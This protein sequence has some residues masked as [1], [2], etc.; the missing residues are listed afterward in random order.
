[1]G[2]IGME[3]AWARLT[4]TLARRPAPPPERLPLAGAAGRVLAADLVARQDVPPFDRATMDGYAVGEGEAGRILEVVGEIHAGDGAVGAVGADAEV[5]PAPAPAAGGAGLRPGTAVRIMTGAPVPPGA[6]RVVMVEATREVDGG[7]RVEILDHGRRRNIAPRGEDLRAGAVAARAG[8]RLTPARLAGL[9]ACGLDEAAVAPRPRVAVLVTGDELVERA[10]DLAPG[11]ILNSNGPLLAGL[12]TGAGYPVRTGPPVPDRPGRT[13]DRIAAALEGADLL[14][15]SGG[16]SAGTRD[17]V[18]GALAALGLEIVFSRVRMKPG[19][20]VTLAVGGRGLA[21]GLPGNPVSVFVTAHLFLLPALAWLEGERA[22]PRWLDLPAAAD[23]AAPASERV[24]LLPARL[25]GRGRWELL[26]YHGS[27]HLLALY[28][29]DGLVRLDPGAERV[30]AGQE[31]P[32][33]PVALP[34]YGTDAAAG[35]DGTGPE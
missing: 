13:R 10:A 22:R 29:A 30:A 14:V 2:M 11:R 16:V 27:G 23:Q 21:L 3:E 33:W 35:A 15:L 9:L 20:P 7:R 18:P 1:M 28:R 19:K 24:Q 25:D 34:A 4:A 5:A 17:H 32:F 8:E 12:V 26:P 6:G 31:R